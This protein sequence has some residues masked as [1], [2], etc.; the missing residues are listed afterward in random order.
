MGCR[1]KKKC[2]FAEEMD[3]RY[4][5][6]LF[7]RAVENAEMVI[8][9]LKVQKQEKNL[10]FLKENIGFIRKKTYYFLLMI[11]KFGSVKMGMLFQERK[12]FY[13]MFKMVEHQILYG[14]V[15]KWDTI[16]QLPVN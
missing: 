8:S 13:Q 10:M 4:S 12:D 16:K 6:D 14:F 11:I 7:R 5:S 3:Q 9:L 15:T 1:R 2:K